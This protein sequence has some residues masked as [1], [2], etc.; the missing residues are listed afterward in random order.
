MKSFLFSCCWLLAAVLATAAEPVR[1]NIVVFIADDL[2][3]EE[4]SPYGHPVVRT[5]NLQRL[6]DEGLRFDR[7][8]LTASSCS[9]S[10][11]SLLSGRYPH[12]IG[13]RDLHVDLKPDVPLLVEPLR[14][15]GYYTML[16]GKS[17]GTN[18]PEVRRKFDRMDLADWNQPWTVVDQWEKALRERPRDRPFFMWAAS[19]DPHRPYRQGD[20]AR[21]YQ[22]EEVVVPPY[23]PDIPEVRADL[24]GYYDEITRLD[25]HIGRVLRL[26]EAEGELD[27]T[28]IVF[29][30]DNG[31]AFPHAKTRVNVPG[32][33]SPLLV[34]YP[35]LIRPGGVTGAL[36]SAVDFAPTLLELARAAPL[37]HPDG[38]SLVPVLRD[39]A[40]TVRT[41]AFAGHNWHSFRAYERAVITADALYSRN[42]LPEFSNPPPGEVVPTPAY[43]AMWALFEAGRLP[44]EQAGT[45]LAPRP[46]EELFLVNDDPHCLRNQIGEPAQAARLARLRAQLAEWQ[47]QTGDTFPGA[48]KLRADEVDRRTGVSLKKKPAAKKAPVTP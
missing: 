45:F 4:C 40:A 14:T 29:L 31:R 34:R 20:Y 37:P 9:P 19:T 8:F 38:V 33:K 30:T 13:T 25:D 5:P 15:A 39:P 16:V 21:P 23:Y 26:L 44:P 3:W 48:D 35:P 32:L 43:Q 24:A 28:V 1:P 18:H 10:R 36:A 46:A 41:V 42:W 11:T 17:H 22:P 12:S 27:R 6:A 7:F 2:G 47:Q